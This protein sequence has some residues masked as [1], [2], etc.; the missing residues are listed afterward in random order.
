MTE[1]LLFGAF[2]LY[3]AGIFGR[4]GNSHVTRAH[5]AR[6]TASR[7]TRLVVCLHDARGVRSP[8]P[9]GLLP[10][11]YF[12][13]RDSPRRSFP[14]VELDRVVRR[15]SGRGYGKTA[16]GA[17][18]DGRI[19][20]FRPFLAL[21]ILLLSSSPSAP[22]LYG[23]SCCSSRGRS[24]RRPSSWST[25]RSWYHDQWTPWPLR[26]WVASSPVSPVCWS[27][28]SRSL[29]ATSCRLAYEVLPHRRRSRLY[30]WVFL[31]CVGLAIAITVGLLMGP[32]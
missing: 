8:R 12:C 26:P 29:L 19:L 14:A 9:S 4:C 5:R 15:G 23:S 28:S 16:L 2:S 10:P 1:L 17:S 21:L 25:R 27:S 32:R 31:A 3:W 13:S 30:L 11:S 6:A 22:G 24:T 18:R 7:R 20:S